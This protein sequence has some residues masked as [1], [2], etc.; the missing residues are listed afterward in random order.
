MTLL[1]NTGAN[2]LA[3]NT[4]LKPGINPVVVLKLVSGVQP[5]LIFKPNK[6]SAVGPLDGALCTFNVIPLI[7]PG[8]MPAAINSSARIKYC[9]R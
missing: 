4:L 6:L 2:L 7:L 8:L 9:A 1:P 5:N 3:V